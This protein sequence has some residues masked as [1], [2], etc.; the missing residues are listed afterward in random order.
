MDPTPI[1]DVRSGVSSIV[2]QFSEALDVFQKWRVGR[3]GKKAVGQEECKT[4][5]EEGKST[6]EDKFNQCLQQHGARFDRGD[7]IC[8]DV[9]IDTRAK[10]DKGV[11]ESLSRHVAGKL[12]KGEKINPLELIVV[13]ESTRKETIIAMDELSRRISNGSVGPYTTVDPGDVLPPMPLRPVRIPQT[14]GTNSN[15]SRTSVT[16][17][18]QGVEDRSSGTL[19]LRPQASQ[20]S[21]AS[22][23]SSQTSFPTP[24]APIPQRFSTQVPSTWSFPDF[25]TSQALV[26]ARPSSS[27]TAL[28]WMKDMIPIKPTRPYYDITPLKPTPDVVPTFT[29]DVDTEDILDEGARATQ[30]LWAAVDCEE[31]SRLRAHAHSAPIPQGPWKSMF[32]EDEDEDD[33]DR[34]QAPLPHRE[35][36]SSTLPV[37]ES[38]HMFLTPRLPGA[39]PSSAQG[40]RRVRS[41]PMLEFSVATPR[42]RRHVSNPATRPK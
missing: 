21:F 38:S 24:F 10:F 40:E 33:D 14:L 13:S 1:V 8:I 19:H 22:V 12:S 42:F 9:L 26:R 11:L 34:S 37:D 39:R 36:S 23:N 28:S 4:S 18:L 35:E 16:S 17:N 7:R 31:N 41:Q 15:L 5:F 20:A 3:A 32:G 27:A 2:H 6:I 29:Y 25:G 30:K